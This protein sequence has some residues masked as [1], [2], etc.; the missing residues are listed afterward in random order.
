MAE[1]YNGT[2][3]EANFGWDT[4]VEDLN[5]FYDVSSPWSFSLRRYDSLRLSL[6][7]CDDY[8]AL[9]ALDALSSRAEH[10]DMSLRIMLRSS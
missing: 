1:E 6:L 4:G 8:G 9:L 3:T 2:T 10:G 5:I 7:T